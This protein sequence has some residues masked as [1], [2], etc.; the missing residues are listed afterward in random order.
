MPAYWLVDP[1]TPR[2]TVLRSIDGSFIEEAVVTGRETYNATI[3]FE[4][5]VVPTDLVA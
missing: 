1:L 4:V 3:P 2:L 5:T